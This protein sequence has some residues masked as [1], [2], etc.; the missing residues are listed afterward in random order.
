MKKL[1]LFLT[2]AVV[3]AGSMQAEINVENTKLKLKIMK[4]LIPVSDIVFLASVGCTL[5]SLMPGA[6]CVTIPTTICAQTLTASQIY[7]PMNWVFFSSISSAAAR[8][9][10]LGLKYD[11]VT[12]KAN[13]S[14]K[15]RA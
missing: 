9:Y 7:G 5:L 3:S 15:V 14:N 1:L 13:P 10:Q 11:L 2:I 4:E 6:N 12:A 8:L